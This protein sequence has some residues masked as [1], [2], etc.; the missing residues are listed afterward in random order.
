LVASHRND[1]FE[2]VHFVTLVNKTRSAAQKKTLH[3]TERD[4][5]VNQE[6][7]QVWCD[8]IAEIDPARFVFVD[9]SGVTRSM[10]RR[11][12]RAP[13][14]ERVSGAVPFGRWEV[15]TLMG[16]LALDGVRAS[17]SVDAATDT[18]I[19]QVFVEQILRPVLRSGDVVI[20]DNLPAHKAPE[21]QAH[22]EA[23][24][25]TLLP[26]PPYS[27]DFNPIEQC[28]SKVKEFLRTAEAR[29]AEALEQAIA[30]AFASVTVPD[31]H[32]WFQHCGYGPV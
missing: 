18:D 14:G 27:P 6:K 26:L 16:A 5:A 11:Y 20:W 2:P 10:T 8:Q 1:P 25:A 7:R 9:E 23:A 21:L 15:T 17:F 29:T 32:G 13:K 22:I 28:W 19:F 4:T 30:Q 31:A 12:G 24:Q 3:A